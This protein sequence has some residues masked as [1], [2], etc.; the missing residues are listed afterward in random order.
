MF[1][2]ISLAL[3]FAATLPAVAGAQNCARTITA[4]VVA[5]DQVFFWNR[6]GAVQPQGQMYALRRDVVPISGSTLS[7]GNVQLRP[8]SARAPWRC[9]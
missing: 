9:A 4:D 5:F 1:R 7:P 2:K 6:L 3:L 8:A